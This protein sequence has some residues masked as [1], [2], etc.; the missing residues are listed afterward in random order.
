MLLIKKCRQPRPSLY[1]RTRRCRSRS[2]AGAA[3]LLS[4]SAADAAV[5]LSLSAAA[6]FA[7][8]AL[9][10]ACHPRPADRAGAS[11]QAPSAQKAG[12]V[13]PT[14]TLLISGEVHN[15]TEP[16]GCTSDPL[17]DVARVAGLLN[18]AH[19]PALLLDAGGLRYS[20]EALSPEHMRQARLKADYLE[21][22]FAGLGAIV[23]LQPE[24]L[25]G[26]T[27]ELS[28]A[29]RVAANLSGLPPEIVV[30]TELRKVGTVRVG[31]IGLAAPRDGDGESWPAGIAVSDPIAAAR[32]E[33]ERL[34]KEGADLV[35]ALTGLPR[36]QGRRLL[37]AVPGLD[38]VVAGGA[39]ED[40]VEEA[41][42][43]TEA[44]AQAGGGLLVV[45]AKEAQR[46]VRLDFYGTPKGTLRYALSHSQAE[47]A[48]ERQRLVYRRKFAREQLDRL[49]ADP[50]ADPAFVQSTREDLSRVD[51][52]LLSVKAAH[53]PPAG[54]YVVMELCPITRALP[55]D[56]EVA[57]TLAALDQKV[58]KENLK[59]V[60]GPPPAPPKGQPAY[61]GTV[62]CA[63]SC[64]WHDEAVE[65]WQKTIHAGAWKTLLDAGKQ[66][67]LDCV[68]CH[69]V[70]FGE[71][72]GSNLRTLVEGTD[73]G[74][75]LRNVGCEACHG[76]GSRHVAA[77]SKV[78]MPVPVPGEVRCQ[79]CHTKQHSD[80]FQ[81]QAYLRDILGPG[82]GE[83]RRK[84]L[85]P[86]VTAHELRQAAL[87]KHKPAP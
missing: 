34:R 3:V 68:Q 62:A 19:S 59:A 4:R 61:V 8:L 85:L 18:G 86:G 23:A 35:V 47:L 7:G 26:G 54:P 16:C 41:E 5:L 79:T 60:T 43:D 14:L 2:A 83:D 55:R 72:G 46:I 45:P 20:Q 82:H 84:A 33:L 11:E 29:R 71:L 31:V 36:Q 73:R 70:G 21:R 52:A 66:L 15:A 74:A 38:V 76:P 22:T 56:P 80:T 13:I 48:R 75:E 6:L 12:D 30:P 50:A 49:L 81:F 65:S 53:A 77:P 9:L 57:R 10:S 67:S 39:L 51:T 87:A 25:R 58:G 78:P 24:D 1:S 17:G 32:K 28:E 40:G 64:H 63:G 27:A 69:V 44:G 37:R 42:A